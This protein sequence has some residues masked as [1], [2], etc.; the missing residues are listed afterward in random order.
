[1]GSLEMVQNPKFHGSG[2][3]NPIAVAQLEKTR[4]IR[5]EAKQY[6][7]E[8]Q[9]LGAAQNA[10][11]S[12]VRRL[13]A[14]NQRVKLEGR[15]TPSRARN[16]RQKPEFAQEALG[17]DSVASKN[18]TWTRMAA[19]ED[20]EYFVMMPLDRPVGSCPGVILLTIEVHMFRES[21]AKRNKCTLCFVHCTSYILRYKLSTYK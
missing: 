10:L 6:A 9:Q 14:Q 4:K 1:M 11:A 7:A 12:E 2:A 13:R 15:T 5:D 3:R 17:D 8:S 19:D 18:T 16:R 20:G 21:T